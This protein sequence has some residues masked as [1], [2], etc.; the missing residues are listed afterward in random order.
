MRG[1][2]VVF[3]LIVCTGACDDRSYQSREEDQLVVLMEMLNDRQDVYRQAPEPESRR[4]RE[5]E[6]ITPLF[7][8]T[9]FETEFIC[10]THVPAPYTDDLRALHGTLI[11]VF[12]EH[13]QLGLYKDGVLFTKDGQD[14]CF[15]IA[16]GSKPQGPKTMRDYSSTPEGWYHV[17]EKRDVGQTAFYRGFLLS[18]PNREDVARAQALGILRS[19]VAWQLLRSIRAGQFPSQGT[20]M[21]GMILI[22]G[23]GSSVS[24]WTAG[25]VAVENEVMDLLFSHIKIRDDILLIPWKTSEQATAR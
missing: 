1:W 12:K 19:A 17:A 22:H 18:Y 2:W 6:A 21:G 7:P 23:M 25:C 11:V 8:S 15:H 13:Y 10:P 4:M 3:A 20:V 14:F 9:P 16:M 24:D 5:R